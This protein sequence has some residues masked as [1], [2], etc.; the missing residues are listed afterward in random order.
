MKANLKF[1]SALLS[2]SLPMADVVNAQITC[3]EIQTLKVNEKVT[4][5]VT[6][7][8]KIK[9]VDISTEE[10]AADQP[11]ENIVRFKPKTDFSK[12][13]EGKMLAVVTIVTER[14]RVQYALAY[15]SDVMEAVTDKTIFYSETTPYNNPAV[16]MSMTEMAMFSRRIW[17]SPALYHGVGVRR[18]RI[19][20]KINNIYS[21]GEYFF[22]DFSL[23][24][25]SNIRFDI[26]Q[27]RVKME[28]KKK[29]RASNCQ[30][31]ELT[32]VFSLENAKSF[33]HGY[34]NVL[35][36]KKLT[37]PNDKVL[38]IE[39]S[40]KQISGRNISVNIEYEDVLSADTF[41]DKLLR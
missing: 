6:S 40:E 29:V 18:N 14:H 28:D 33:F 31:V 36:L 17:N 26:D 7:P 24:N 11:L 9:L 3:N 12:N 19:T 27:I 10:V 5:V 38:T 1:I 34:R 15:T 22:L 35:V 13:E 21:V 8:E 20:M 30:S 41:R 16:S 23:E 37:F 25:H 4:T 2:I 32:P 39:I